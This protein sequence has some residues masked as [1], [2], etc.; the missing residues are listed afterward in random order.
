MG[1]F[2]NGVIAPNSTA[3]RSSLHTTPPW[4]KAIAMQKQ[5]NHESFS[6]KVKIKRV[7]GC[8]LSRP[9]HEAGENEGWAA[10]RERKA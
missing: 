9:I 2:K 7:L 10:N 6:K 3:W 4:L 8:A 1:I 5:D